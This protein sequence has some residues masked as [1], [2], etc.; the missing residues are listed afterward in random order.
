[1]ASNGRQ[2][3]LVASHLGK[4]ASACILVGCKMEEEPRRIRDVVNLSRLLGLPSWEDDDNGTDDDREDSNGKCVDASDTTGKDEPRSAGIDDGGRRG[5]EGGR[6]NDGHVG[7][8]STTT[9]IVKSPMAWAWRCAIRSLC[10]PARPFHSPP[11]REGRAAAA[12]VARLLLMTNML[13]ERPG[14]MLGVTLE[15]CNA[16]AVGGNTTIN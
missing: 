5:G 11:P 14:T 9:T 6:N 10:C 3:R 2:R 4:V 16:M 1:M 7:R 12:A 8:R 15:R 13:P